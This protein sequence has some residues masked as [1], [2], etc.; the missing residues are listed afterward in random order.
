M[1]LVG[2]ASTGADRQLV[3]NKNKKPEK[4]TMPEIDLDTTTTEAP[5]NAIAEKENTAIASF[6]PADGLMGEITADDTRIPTLNIV[7]GVGPLSEDFNP[8]SLVYNRETVLADGSKDGSKTAI[9]LTV[10]VARKQYTENLEWGSDSLPRVVDTLEEVRE[11]GGS[12]AWVNNERPS[13]LPML[14]CICLIK[15][16]PDMPGFDYALDGDYYAP[17]LW[18]IKGSAAYNR[19]AKSIITAGSMGLRERGLAS[20]L[21]SL[22]ARREKLGENFVYVPLLVQKGKNSEAFVEAVKQLGLGL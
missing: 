10:V 7:H 16:D 2:R 12:I 4:K 15:G 17:A 5:S 18:V 1:T 3:E 9:D 19:A 14:K 11:A 6:E 8:G 13:W 21:W 20:G 22:S